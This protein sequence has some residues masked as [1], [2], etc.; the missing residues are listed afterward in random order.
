DVASARR[1][2]RVDSDSG[3]VR[4]EDAPVG[5]TRLRVR[6]LQDVLPGSPAQEQL[7]DVQRDGEQERPERDRRDRVEERLASIEKP[8]DIVHGLNVAGA[9]AGEDG[10]AAATYD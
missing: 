2:E 4:A 3:H 8:P 10:V 6:R 9:G 5:D 1:C 7:Q